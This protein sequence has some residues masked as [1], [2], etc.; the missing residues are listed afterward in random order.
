MT[1]EEVKLNH[2]TPAIEKAGWDK[3]QIRMEYP[4]TAG[5]IVVRGNTVKRESKKFA[6]YLLMYKGDSIPLAIVEAKDDSHLFGD[7]M[8]QAQEYAKKI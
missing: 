4:I 8:L 7:G 5:K 1:E 2:I 3:K 6:D